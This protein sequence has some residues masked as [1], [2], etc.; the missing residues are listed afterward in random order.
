MAGSKT[1]GTNF[2]KQSKQSERDPTVDFGRGMYNWQVS[3]IHIDSGVG[4]SFPAFITDYSETYTSDWNEDSYFGRNDKIGRFGGTSRSISLSMDLPSWSMKEARL[5][6]HQIE[7]LVATMY[8]SYKTVDNSVNVMNAYPLVKIKFANLIRNSDVPN[9]PIPL[10]SGLTGWIP[11]LNI[12]PDLEAGFHSKSAKSE[13]DGTQEADPKGGI[14]YPKVWKLSFTFKVVHE[15]SMGWKDSRWITDSKRFPYGAYTGFTEKNQ[16]YGTA[17]VT[18]E[19]AAEIAAGA[20]TEAPT[21]DPSAD[22]TKKVAS[23]ATKGVLESG[24]K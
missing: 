9:S 19:T 16:D 5:N 21:V 4:A 3:I 14:L 12:N 23:R 17:V 2:H 15:H 20:S 10:K 24:N 22:V 7:H 1:H 18:A 8:P 13:K 11:N 6:L